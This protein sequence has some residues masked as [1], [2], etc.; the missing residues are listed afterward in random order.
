ME[1]LDKEISVEGT[2]A[3]MATFMDRDQEDRGMVSEY[4]FR[5]CSS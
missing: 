5:Y 2:K 3:L 4:D 1:R